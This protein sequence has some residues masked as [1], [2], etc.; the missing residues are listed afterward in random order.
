[1][2]TQLVDGKDLIQTAFEHLKNRDFADRKPRF[3]THQFISVCGM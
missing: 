1:M 3:R 2:L